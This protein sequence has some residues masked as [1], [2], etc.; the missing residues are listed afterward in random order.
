MGRNWIWLVVSLC[1]LPAC[2]RPPLGGPNAGQ[3]DLRINNSNGGR[4]DVVEAGVV[5]E[6]CEQP[7]C[8]YSFD[9][10]KVLDIVPNV[11]DLNFGAF[12]GDCSADT[13]QLTMNADYTVST[14]FT[15]T[16]QVGLN[17]VLADST[18]DINTSTE[19]HTCPADCFVELPAGGD[20]DITINPLRAFFL[21]WDGDCAAITDQTCTL[22]LDQHRTL[23]VMF[24]PYDLSAFGT[25]NDERITAVAK[26]PTD[27]A[28]LII[29]GT[30]TK[31]FNLFG[32]AVTQTGSG[33][34][35]F[36]ARI[37]GKGNVAWVYAFGGDG[38]GV[39]N[40]LTT[41]TEATQ[42]VV[43][44]GGH[45]GGEVDIDLDG[46][47]ANNDIGGEPNGF[48]LKLHPD[49]NAAAP[50]W[51]RG[52]EAVSN[53][54]GDSIVQGIAY[55]ANNTDV[56]IT[57]I[58]TGEIDLDGQGNVTEDSGNA[59]NRDYLFVGRYNSDD[60]VAEAIWSVGSGG[61]S[62]MEGG[63][64]LVTP[65][66]DIIVAGW[67]GDDILQGDTTF[68]WSSANCVLYPANGYDA[69][70]FKADRSGVCIWTQAIL[71][72]GDQR[73]TSV[74]IDPVTGDVYVAGLDD[75]T[76][77]ASSFTSTG[78]LRW[79]QPILTT[80]ATAPSVAWDALASEVVLVGG[81]TTDF[82]VDD[83][84]GTPQ[85]LPAIG[86]D[87]VMLLH[88]QAVNGRA[89]DFSTPSDTGDE[90]SG[91]PGDA[92]MNGD[93]LGYAS[94]TCTV[95]GDGTTVVVGGSTSAPFDING[96]PYMGSGGL[97]S[98]FIEQAPRA[99]P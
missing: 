31:D 11:T 41:A 95:L 39:V 75:G 8:E 51:A 74:D 32:T 13:C 96:I 56:F 78:T 63:D 97:D 9:A 66:D 43:Y 4:L 76:A 69:L 53:N 99:V 80:G 77:L 59:S 3:H 70:L 50:V 21:G 29:A 34:N 58:Y 57:G 20:V 44:A 85:T 84:T 65:Q 81:F 98:Y 30:F 19:S 72:A 67:I 2:G 79:T 12:G 92:L 49:V 35:F 36:I 38:D 54:D 87:D 62:R 22:K 52:I 28:G 73:Y 17:G 7:V 93:R 64:I 45:Y 27:V 10:G 25:D 61:G 15:A 14:S 24:H 46:D 40:A 55:G 37:V 23:G 6:T 91:S 26:D 94:S 90:G 18:I 71:A 86:G 1:A 89:A 88:L 16:V 83:T 47:P 82:T 33:Q 48:V 42:L 68:D 5:L 60:G